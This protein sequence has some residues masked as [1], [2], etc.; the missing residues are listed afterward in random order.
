MELIL[1]LDIAFILSLQNLGEWLIGPMEFFTFLA[2]EEFFLFVAPVIYWCWDASLG[3]RLGLI[4][5][6]SDVLCN[7]LKLVFHGPRSYWYDRRVRAFATETSFG[8]PSSHTQNAVI[9]WGT[10]AAWVNRRWAWIAAVVIA[11][12]KH[13]NPPAQTMIALV[14][15][16]ARILGE[17]ET[18]NLH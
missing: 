2:K 6:V 1:D 3:L 17:M 11:W 18:S 12:L 15:S 4:L 13:F 14:A 16:L 10:L 7:V 8:V 9:L 5:M